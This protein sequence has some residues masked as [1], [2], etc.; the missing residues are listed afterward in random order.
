MNVFEK[1]QARLSGA[2]GP[3]RHPTSPAPGSASGTRPARAPEVRQ[4]VC[5]ECGGNALEVTDGDRTVTRLACPDC[6]L[7]ER[8]EMLSA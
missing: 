1:I 3:A 8:I 7:A 6:G 5:P 4:R 2:A